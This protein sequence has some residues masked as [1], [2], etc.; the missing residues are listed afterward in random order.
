MNLPVDMLEVETMLDT[1]FAEP[2]FYSTDHHIL[3]VADCRIL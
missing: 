1:L 2:F 3:V